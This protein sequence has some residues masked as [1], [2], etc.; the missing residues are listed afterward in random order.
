MR[1]L[2][3]VSAFG[4]FATVGAASIGAIA[5]GRSVDQSRQPAKGAGHL[6]FAAA[7]SGRRSSSAPDLCRAWS[8]HLLGNQ[9]F[10][11]TE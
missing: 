11:S 1:G 4:S 3:R 2:V 6:W 8:H 9:L 5:A 10:S 7:C